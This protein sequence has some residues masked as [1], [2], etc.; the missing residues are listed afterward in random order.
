MLLQMN[1]LRTCFIAIFLLISLFLL[2][3]PVRADGFPI[4]GIL[5]TGQHPEGIAVD[6][7]THLVYIADETPGMI[8]AFDPVANK[9]RWQVKM[10][11][12]ATDVQVD[13]A[14]H[15]V[16]VSSYAFNVTRPNNGNQLQAG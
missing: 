10:G 15:Q 2:P 4:I 3:P 8:V 11:D 16:Y 1:L 5:H 6:T 13:S 9:V 14:N 7:Q 12:V